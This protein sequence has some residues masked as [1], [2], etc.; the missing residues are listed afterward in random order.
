[1]R[2]RKLF[3]EYERGLV[4]LRE[5][6]RRAVLSLLRAL[7]CSKSEFDGSKVESFAQIH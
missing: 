3:A 2:A 4:F 6:I 7:A 1:M 5:L